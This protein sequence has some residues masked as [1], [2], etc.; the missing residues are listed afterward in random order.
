MLTQDHVSPS[1]YGIYDEYENMK[2]NGPMSLEMKRK[3]QTRLTCQGLKD[4]IKK[5]NREKNSKVAVSGYLAA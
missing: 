3:L 2:L 5:T 1:I 4:V